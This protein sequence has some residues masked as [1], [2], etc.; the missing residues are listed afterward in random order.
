MSDLPAFDEILNFRDMGG[1]PAADGVIAANRL[2]RSGH[3]SGASAADL[4]RL[5]SLGL[6]GIVD[7]RVEI[8]MQGDGGADP[9]I[10]GAS[11]IPMPVVDEDGWVSDLRRILIEAD[12]DLLDETYGGGR[13]RD[14]AIQGAVSQATDPSKQAVYGDFLRLVA[15][16]D[17]RP[18]LF[19]CSAGKDRTGWAATLVGMVVGV[20]D[21]QLIAH[22]MESNRQD[23][24][25]LRLEHY[26]Q[27]GLDAT[28]ITPL[29]QVEEANLDAA[30]EAIDQRWESRQTYLEEALG[31]DE[32]SAE[33]IRSR[34]VV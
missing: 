7:F 9:V 4:E 23:F 2:Y 14:M 10:P 29:M 5:A 8:D 26:A 30:L 12:Q 6:G 21:S 13:A 28:V 27:R 15:N 24:V 17:T 33:T 19:H 31:V 32:A 16:G 11:P 1:L 20:P 3:L 18:L 25:S 34:L 22:Y